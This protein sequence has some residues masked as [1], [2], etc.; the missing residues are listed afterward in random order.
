MPDPSL[1]IDPTDRDRALR[2]RLGRIEPAL[3]A[4][5][6]CSAAREGGGGFIPSRRRVASRGV[7]GQAAD[8]ERAR[9]EAG[10]RARRQLRC[11]CAANRL[12]KLGTLTYRGAV[13]GH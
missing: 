6:L 2:T 8:P 4:L 9:V 13:K 11:Y 1:P 10:R 5:S 7:R 3:W 12:N